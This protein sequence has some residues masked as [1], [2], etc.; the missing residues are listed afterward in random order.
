MEEAPAGKLASKLLYLEDGVTIQRNN[1]T[2]VMVLR[3]KRRGQ[4]G[5]DES[6]KRWLQHDRL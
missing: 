6:E 5:S 1:C 4:M 2:W 3:F